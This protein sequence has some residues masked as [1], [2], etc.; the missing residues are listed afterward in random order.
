MPRVTEVGYR[1]CLTDHEFARKRLV[2]LAATYLIL[3]FLSVSMMKDPYFIVG[4]DKPYVLPAHL[5]GI[6]PWLLL[7]YREVFC[8]VA[9]LSAIEA[10]FSLND[11]VQYWLLKSLFPF[12]AALWHH[13]STFGSVSNI[14]DRG[15]AGWW[16]AWWHQTFRQQ[17]LAPSTYLVRYG[18]LERGSRKAT[19]VAMFMSFFQS[20][21][22]HASGSISSVPK[23]KPWRSPAFFLLQA[24]GILIQEGLAK[25]IGPYLP[26]P[27]RA[28][29]RAAHLLFTIAW[30]YMTAGLFINDLA[31]T[32]TVATGARPNL[33]ATLVGIW[34]CHRSLVALGS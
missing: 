28:L 24:V 10:V 34:T 13:A 27:P 14:L 12:R 1:R 7:A 15:L 11:L 26:N 5:Q 18:Y 9:V 2:N 4:P 25:A 16:G 17:F 19:I 33:T 32:G 21:L 29:T 22:L 3:D 20:G 31:S 30:M 23:T 6:S 8:L